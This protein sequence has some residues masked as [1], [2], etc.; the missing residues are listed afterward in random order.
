MIC[1]C[2]CPGHCHSRATEF[3]GHRLSGPAPPGQRA[4]HQPGRSRNSHG[5]R[6]LSRVC[7]SWARDSVARPGPAEFRLQVTHRQ[8]VTVRSHC[9][10]LFCDRW[11]QWQA[12]DHD[13]CHSDQ[14]PV[15]VIVST[16]PCMAPWASVQVASY[17]PGFP[18]SQSLISVRF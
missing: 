12:A 7:P 8:A 3:P 16:K 15:P 10:S 18:D 14:I 9:L 11:C 1:H 4:P 5:P 17:Q 6:Q 2:H 13:H